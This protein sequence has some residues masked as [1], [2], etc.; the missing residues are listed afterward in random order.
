MHKKI[1]VVVDDRAVTQSA[2]RQ[3]IEMAHASRADL[4]FISVLP[5]QGALGLEFF[6]EAELSYSDFQREAIAHARKMLSV[7]SNWAEHAGVQNFC[8]IGAGSNGAQCVSDFAA[9]N[10]CDLIVVGSEAKN[11][12]LQFLNG[13]IVPGLISVA[14]VPVLVCGASISNGGFSHRDTGFIRARQR[15]QELLE[16]RRQEKND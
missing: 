8:A 1:L 12:V 2:I 16:R 6:A 9:K 10:H 3:A 15:R 14:A 11:A 13:S 7:A 4:H 5:V